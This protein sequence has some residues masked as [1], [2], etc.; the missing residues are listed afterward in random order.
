[1]LPIALWLPERKLGRQDT[2]PGNRVSSD[3]DVECAST[4]DPGRGVLGGR[5]EVARLD[6]RGESLDQ[7]TP[8]RL[9]EL[10]KVVDLI[11][12]PRLLEEVLAK[13]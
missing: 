1:M 5:R 8:P 2:S 13:V 6:D 3:P 4:F 7:D 9:V 11:A 12:H 10:A